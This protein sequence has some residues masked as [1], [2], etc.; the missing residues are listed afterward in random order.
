MDDIFD[1]DLFHSL[2]QARDLR[3][4]VEEG[5]PTNHFLT[6]LL[7]N[8]LITCVARA[9]ARNKAVLADYVMWLRSYAPGDCYGSPKAVAAWISVGG[10]ASGQD[11]S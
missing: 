5:R 9:D 2:P 8:D 3:H 10:M 4:Y 7:E 11:E 6:A 1:N